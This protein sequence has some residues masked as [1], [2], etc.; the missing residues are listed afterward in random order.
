MQGLTFQGDLD[1]FWQHATEPDAELY[2]NFRNTVIHTTQINGGFYTRAG[3]NLVVRNCY[4]AL[5][6]PR[7]PLEHLIQK[8]GDPTKDI[9]PTS[10]T[11]FASEPLSKAM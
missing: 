8:T 7:S 5:I 1:Q 3:V 4:E 6:A 2:Q 9:T 11:R 10:I